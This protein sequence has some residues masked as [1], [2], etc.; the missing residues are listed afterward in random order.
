M[1]G[2]D[3]ASATQASN[4]QSTLALVKCMESNQPPVPIF[5]H[6]MR[7]WSFVS[8]TDKVSCVFVLKF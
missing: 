8:K 1:L 5:T 7:P 6:G 4:T 3:I 2:A